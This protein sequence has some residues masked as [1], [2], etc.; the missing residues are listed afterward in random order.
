MIVAVS[1]ANI[2]PGP[3]E[4]QPAMLQREIAFRGI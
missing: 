4:I 2:S 3:R 1:P